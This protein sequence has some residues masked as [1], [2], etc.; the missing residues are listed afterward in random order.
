MLIFKKC[1]VGHYSTHIETSSS[2]CNVQK[3]TGF[4]KNGSEEFTTFLEGLLTGVKKFGYKPL[5]SINTSTFQRQERER[6]TAISG[7]TVTR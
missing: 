1:Y 2:I 3:W 4:F 6:E 7:K 5:R